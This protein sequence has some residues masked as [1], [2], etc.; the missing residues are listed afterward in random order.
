MSDLDRYSGVLPEGVRSVWPKLAEAVAGIKGALFG[1]TA[2]ATH[3]QHRQSFDL[4]YMTYEHFD[5]AALAERLAA[6]AQVD[7][8]VASASQMRATVDGVVVE[9]FAAPHPRDDPSRVRQIADPATIAGLAV[10]SLPDLAASK[11]DVLLWRAK[12]RDFIDIAAID[13]S[14]L[15]RIEDALR[16]HTHRY[17][18]ELRSGVLDEIV[19]LLEDPGVLASDPI[20][21]GEAAATLSYLAGRV[22]ALREYL[23]AARAVSGGM[24]AG[25]SGSPNPKTGPDAADPAVGASAKASPLGATL[26][27]AAAPMLGIAPPPRRTARALILD[28]LRAHPKASYGEI[29]RRVDTTA[30]YVGR[31]A[32]SAGLARRPQQR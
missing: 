17:G 32:R 7:A 18:T 19:D 25:R 14:G 22:P 10:A 21:A 13:R 20:F 26:P 2:L 1:G 15:L 29:A 9:V 4:D 3:L 27:A 8:H 12:L 28:A 16:L 31:V 30:N 11:L 5:G 24:P 6:A 23:A